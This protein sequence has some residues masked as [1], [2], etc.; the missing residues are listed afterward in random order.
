MTKLTILISISLDEAV[1]KAVKP[2]YLD[3]INPV[4]L[5]GC[6]HGLTQNQNESFNSMIWERA[7]KT[8]Y[9]GYDKLEFAVYDACAHFNYG[10]EATIDILRIMNVDAGY[11]TRMMCYELNKRRKYC[12]TF[13]SKASSKTARKIIRANKKKKVV[14]QRLRARYTKQ[15]AF[16]H[17]K[18][19]KQEYYLW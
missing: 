7:P 18:C 4:E 8:T 15:V 14:K 2:I 16:K 1:I 9:C 6:L 10:R 19:M 5:K 12:A 17:S 11:Y 3:L 13:K